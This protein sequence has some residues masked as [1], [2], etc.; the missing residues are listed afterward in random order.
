MVDKLRE[1]IN[2]LQ[3]IIDFQE[4]ERRKTESPRESALRLKNDLARQ[5][6]E[7]NRKNLAEMSYYDLFKSIHYSPSK[8][9]RDNYVV[10]E[11]EEIWN[12]LNEHFDLPKYENY[13][14]GFTIDDKNRIVNLI[15]KGELD[16]RGLGG[17]KRKPKDLGPL[18]RRV[19]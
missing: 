18:K 15:E 11:E 19:K 7:M 1:G 4:I 5:R 16:G 14:Y 17:W 8:Y 2:R 9:G 13:K 12:K 6:E 10:G 3:P